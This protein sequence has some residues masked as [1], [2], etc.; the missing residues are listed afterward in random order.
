M[1]KSNKQKAH[2][3]KKK[4][5][6]QSLDQEWNP[7]TVRQGILDY[8]DRFLK[9]AG[10][11][12][13]P[14]VTH[15]TNIYR[16]LDGLVSSKFGR[17]S[18]KTRL[19]LQEHDGKYLFCSGVAI[20]VKQFGKRQK[21]LVAHPN[22]IGTVTGDPYA[23]DVKYIEFP[24][25]RDIDSHIWLDLG[26]VKKIDSHSLNTILFGDIITFVGKS[27]LYRGKVSKNVRARAGKYGLS[28]IT[29]NGAYAATNVGLMYEAKMIYRL[30]NKKTIGVMEYSK[31]AQGY[32][33]IET[34]VHTLPQKL[35]SE[36]IEKLF[37]EEGENFLFMSIFLTQMLKSVPDFKNKVD[38]YN[39]KYPDKPI[40]ERY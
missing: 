40:L 15:L 37:E 4:L 25:E 31:S 16:G 17:T 35:A 24:I 8:V 10:D 5:S 7:E 20:M 1:A 27:S 32:L 23:K 29:I 3:L 26:D 13:D 2:A 14:V 30:S 11:D 21:L 6:K 33:P 28:D 38:K 18:P 36:R 39:K 12:I 9:K 19:A 34:H 22:I